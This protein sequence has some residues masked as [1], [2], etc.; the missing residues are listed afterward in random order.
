MDLRPFKD[1]VRRRSGLML[2]GTA[3]DALAAAVITRMRVTQ[4]D[5]PSAYFTAILA[6]EGEFQELLS[7]VTINETYFFR[8]PA[9]LSFLVDRLV[10]G[11]LA[12][13]GDRPRLRILS[14]GCSTGEE[15]YSIAIALREKFGAGVAQHVSIAAGDIDIHALARAR[16]ATYGEF[17]FRAMPTGLQTRYFTRAGP[18]SFTLNED[19]RALVTFHHLNLL[20][21]HFPP[22]LCGFDVVFF[23]NVSI[24]F[25]PPTRLAI[26]TTLRSLMNDGA[27]LFLGASETLAN[28]LGVL[29]LVEEEGLFHFIKG[30][31]TARPAP[32]A[33]RTTSHP[34]AAPRLP[35]SRPVASPVPPPSPPA[36]PVATLEE[37]RGLIR[38]EDY[39]AAAAVVGRLRAETPDDIGALLLDGYIRLH[40]GDI[41][42]ATTL[43]RE[44]LERDAWSADGGVLL[45]LIAK[46]RGDADQAMIS[47]R[48][49]VYAR[50]DCWPA[51]YHLAGLLRAQD[52]ARARRQYGVVLRLMQAN[53][54]PDGG[55]LLPLNLPLADIRFLCERHGASPARPNTT[56]GVIRRGA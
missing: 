55:L 54:D 24:Y 52:E 41:M 43:A 7:L 19:T 10:P 9:Q 31:V 30:P 8:E 37:A 29:R 35:A 6:D 32:A 49:V 20:S 5:D 12:R 26:L 36:R 50:P 44:A 17:S 56:G 53:P 48:Q 21:E 3:E 45:G 28:D 51:H 42:G 18:R 14:A 2:D 39:P 46:W 47:F 23:R 38:D 1:L 22:E 25:D 40:T 33:P 15:P 16:R 34:P 4:C 27:A 11:L 13:G